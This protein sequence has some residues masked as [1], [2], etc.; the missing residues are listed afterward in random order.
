MKNFNNL[1]WSPWFKE[2]Q[3]GATCNRKHSLTQL[4][5]LCAKHQLRITEFGI[6]ILCCRY[7]VD[8]SI[9]RLVFT[10]VPRRWPCG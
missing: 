3:T 10:Q 4:Q 8:T 2:P 1:P 5:P 6:K 7:L 9:D